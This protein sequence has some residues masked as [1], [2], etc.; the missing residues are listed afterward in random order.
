MNPKQILWTDNNTPPPTNYLWKKDGVILEN[1]NGEW[2]EAEEFKPKETVT[3]GEEEYNITDLNKINNV[4]K[5]FMT[6][7]QDSTIYQDNTYATINNAYATL[8]FYTE[9]QE[10]SECEIHFTEGFGFKRS[11][12]DRNGTAVLDKD[13]Y[14]FK[15]GQNYSLTIFKWNATNESWDEVFGENSTP[16]ESWNFG[17]LREPTGEYHTEKDF[18]G[19][20]IQVPDFREVEIKTPTALVP[21]SIFGNMGNRYW[22]EVY[23]NGEQFIIIPNLS[24]SLDSYA[25]SY[26][27]TTVQ[28]YL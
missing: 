5:F 20:D 9:E 14:R 4:I 18:W 28:R 12:Y 17:T 24:M 7:Y 23:I 10:L 3:I 27:G 25:G 22:F 21:K 15:F 26:S 13:F 2:K 16:I 11:G 8:D 1:V 19:N 6:K